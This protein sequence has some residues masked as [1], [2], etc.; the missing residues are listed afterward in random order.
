MS[1]QRVRT[2]LRALAD[3]APVHPDVAAV[4]RPPKPRSRLVPV[5]AASVLVL[6]V[7]AVALASRVSVF[8]PDPVTQAPPGAADPTIPK[9]F[10]EHSFLQGELSGSFGRASAAYVS[11][12]GHEDYPFPQIIIVG[13][14]SDLYRRVDASVSWGSGISGFRLSPDGTKFVY[15]GD[16][17]EIDVID[18]RTGKRREYDVPDDS[19]A[20][21]VV[22]SADSRYV[23]FLL[24]GRQ[25]AGPAIL[26]DLVSGEHRR[27]ADEATNVVFSPDG[28]ALVLE[29]GDLGGVTVTIVGTDGNVRRSMRLPPQVALAG[30]QAW[31][32]DG[33]YLVVARY[34][35]GGEGGLELIDAATSGRAVTR[36]MPGKPTLP[37]A[38]G[39]AVLG[40]RSP[41][42]MLTSTGD[43]Y[44]TT[45][46]LIVEVDI[47]TGASQIVSRFDT[48]DTDD[49]AVG[50]VQLATDLVPSLSTRDSVHPDR[51]DWPVWAQVA[52][53]VYGLAALLAVATVLLYATT[54]VRR[55]RAT[56]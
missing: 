2:A 36:P 8:A 9:L 13:A 41:T 29:S 32:P 16:E 28:T 33:K 45:S 27:I 26:L 19:K 51:G 22:M 53:T 56:R 35:P 46:N 10:P 49:L 39:D 15:S 1:E 48:R 18:L 20:S 7:F 43:G 38:G 11:G 42:V 52:R 30:S 3:T 34:E 24:K 55:W 4:M 17:G 47:T 23:A 21:S 50:E 31:S 44:G 5:F 25:A 14:D 6:L 40:W 37:R 54:R 12:I